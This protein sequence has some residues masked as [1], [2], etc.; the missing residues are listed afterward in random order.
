MRPSG[1][2]WACAR[3]ALN[4]IITAIAMAPRYASFIECSHLERKRPP[5]SSVT[6]S[7]VPLWAPPGL[8]EPASAQATQVAPV[9]GRHYGC[10]LSLSKALSSNRETAPA[11]GTSSRM[12]RD[13]DL[14][15]V[16]VL[17]ELPGGHGLH[18]P[19]PGCLMCLQQIHKALFDID[20]AREGETVRHESIADLP[21][22]RDEL[23]ER[24]ALLLGG[25]GERRIHV[26]KR[27]H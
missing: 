1:F 25:L 19:F 9:K 16:N 18:D 26:S 14:E 22:R 20:V 24:L 27:Q 6:R 5:F 17:L 21:V 13:G 8:P 11:K 2:G 23:G 10:S 12:L 4:P 3:L 7:G 15:G